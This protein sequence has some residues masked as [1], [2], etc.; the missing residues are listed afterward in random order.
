MTTGRPTPQWNTMRPSKR[1]LRSGAALLP[2][3]LSLVLSLALLL[4]GLLTAVPG[5]AGE[6]AVYESSVGSGLTRTISGPV[7][8]AL[9]DLDYA[10]ISAEGGKLY[11]MSE[12]EIEATGNL[13]LTPTGF[14]C[15]ATSCLYSPLPFAAGRRIRVTAGNDLVGETAAAANL[16]TIGVTGSAGHV[17]LVRGEYLDATGT[18]SSVGSVQNIDVAVLVTVPEPDVATGL[19]AAIGLLG[20]LASVART[21]RAS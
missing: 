2:L 15:Q 10:P 19:L 8:N 21:T 12:L 18:A 17:V 16:L 20:L 5:R 6:L 9:I 13:V 7:T 3:V 4:T 1:E 14:A 11:G